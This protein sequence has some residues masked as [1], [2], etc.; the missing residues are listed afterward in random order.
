MRRTVLFC[1]LLTGLVLGAV[2]PSAGEGSEGPR[3]VRLVVDSPNPTAVA[4]GYH[5]SLKADPGDPHKVT[6]TLGRYNTGKTKTLCEGYNRES[7]FVRTAEGPSGF[8]VQ[9]ESRDLGPP[10]LVAPGGLISKLTMRWSPKPADKPTQWF[11]VF[12]HRLNVHQAGWRGR[13]GVT[14]GRFQQPT[15]R[16]HYEYVDGKP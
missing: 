11:R 13:G 16:F 4:N 14:G 7:V 1:W 2:A 9:P 6:I 3:K 10:R 12:V 15:L 8:Y 5:L